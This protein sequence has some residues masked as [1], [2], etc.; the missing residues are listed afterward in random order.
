[1]LITDTGSVQITKPELVALLAFASKDTTRPHVWCVH[2]DIP[3]GVAAA[4]DGH[5]LV[6]A[7]A[8]LPCKLDAKAFSVPRDRAEQIAKALVA[9]D[10]AEIR[11]G[12][13]AICRRHAMTDALLPPTQTITWNATTGQPFPPY[14]AV[15]P[16]FDR[17]RAGVPVE[18]NPKYIA[19]ATLIAAASGAKGI[20]IHPGDESHSPCVFAAGLWMALVMPRR[21]EDHGPATRLE[22]CKNVRRLMKLAEN[23][24]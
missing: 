19:D 13:A 5:R 6:R 11:D 4:T 7:R 14:D 17:R 1:M 3:N 12:S 23:A 21:R 24:A 22:N 20:I 9:K 2:F 16:P 18:L 8:A 10:V 15:I